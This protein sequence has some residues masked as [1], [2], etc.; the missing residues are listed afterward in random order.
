MWDVGCFVVSARVEYSNKPFRFLTD[1][2]LRV[3]RASVKT[4]T[5]CSAT[6]RTLIVKSA[7]LR[8]KSA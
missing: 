8:V 1:V 2:H 5:R 6:Q 4:E 3:L 7:L